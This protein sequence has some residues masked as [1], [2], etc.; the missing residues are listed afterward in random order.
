MQE[1]VKTNRAAAFDWIGTR[2]PRPDGVD[3]VTG[4][5]RFG[6]DL[7]MQGQLVGKVLRSPHP[8]A[9]IRSIDASA[10][11]AL[12]G[13]K[14]VVTRDDF[15]DQPSQLIPA[16]EQMLNYRDI[17]RNVMAREKALYEGH[18]VAAVAATTA[19]VAKQ[20]LKL[21]KVDYEV[22]PHVIDVVQAMRPGAPLLHEDMITAGVEPAPKAPSNVA[23]R[24]EVGHG[25]LDTGFRRADL[26][27][28]RTF[29]TQP[30]HQGYIEPHACVASVSEDGQADV[31]CTTQGHWMVRA[32]CARL[33]GW[34]TSRIRVTASEIGGGF[35]AKT[36]VY[37]EP[38]ALALAKK[39]RRPVKMVMTREEVFRASGPASGAQVRVKIGARLD[40][41]IVAAEAELKYQAGAFPGSP[42]QP[43]AMCAFAPYDIENVKVVGYD[44]V[45]NRP[46]VAA[47]RAPGAPISEFAV[48][49]VVDDIAA[50]LG[51]DPIELRLRNAARQG[52][53]AAY[54]PKLGPV[55]F[56]E[57]LEAARAHEHWS[58]PLGKNQG[59]GIASGFWFNIGGETSASLQLNEDGTLSLTVGTPDI[60][61]S[62]AA[63]CMM[64]AEELGVDIDS[65]RVQVGDTG[66]LGFNFLTGGSR[67]TF[68]SGMATVEAAREVIR[69]ACKRAARL[70]ELPEDA[71]EYRKGAVRPAGANAGRHAPLTL[72][73]IAGLA[74]KTGG[75][76]AGY[77]RINAQGAAP[78]FGTHIADV[79][80][81]PE[82]GRV[83]VVRYTAIQDAGR[84]IHPSYV[85]GQYQ[86]GVAQGIGWALNEEYI[87]GP[88]G[89]LQNPGFLDYRVPV[90]SDLPMIDT[91]IVEVPNPRHPYGVRGVG[92]TPIVPP[93]AAVANAVANATGVRFADLPMSP[94]RVLAALDEARARGAA[95]I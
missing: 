16:G 64:A 20:A 34:E 40:G 32:Q 70:W 21:I 87:Y 44:V 33:L 36:V 78:S 77:A 1:K 25:D 67:A 65:I 37:L 23:K 86:G 92:E 80:V 93:L 22:L 28:E 88:D 18:A 72:R 91:V 46:K 29:T 79:E 31:W 71:V 49:C 82:T 15:K 9:R 56:I 76:I 61:G 24:V 94:P 57:T 5:A 60:G 19:S 89:R 10:A 6:A 38:L 43:G 8:H 26:V 17:V 63:M 53:K 47:Y 74:G 90:A 13:V 83:A 54:G 73:D 51:M 27:V 66:Q 39:A 50:R 52:T 3:K 81:D 4:R 7:A 62:R 58:A 35:G 55:G 14:A 84:A 69:E 11:A 75:P 12:P 42:V 41:R 95:K 68:S 45:T 30:V 59:R 85:E 2:P 48:E